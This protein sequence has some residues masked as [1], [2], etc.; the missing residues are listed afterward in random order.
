MGDYTHN[1]YGG[2]FSE[3][4]NHFVNTIIRMTNPMLSKLNSL[5]SNIAKL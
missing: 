2:F 4:D 5:V 3:N 1:L